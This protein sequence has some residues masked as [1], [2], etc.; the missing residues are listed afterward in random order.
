MR[1]VFSLLILFITMVFFLFFP[2]AYCQEA[3]KVQGK[4]L[5][6]QDGSSASRYRGKEKPKES[7]RASSYELIHEISSGINYGMS[8][9]SVKTADQDAKTTLSDND[10]KARVSYGIILN[11][12]IEPIIEAQYNQS[13]RKVA[14]F[15]E[16]DVSY[17][18]ALGLLLNLPIE[19]SRKG[20]KTSSSFLNASWVPYLGF[21]LG[22]G[23][24]NSKTGNETLVSSTDAGT[25]TNLIFGARYLIYPHV[26]INMSLRLLYEQNQNEAKTTDE[27][28]ATRSE[29]KIDFR[30]LELSLFI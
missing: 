25:Y 22:V 12:N 18:F 10:L 14:D 6:D 11:D 30:L 4:G 19:S 13:K 23:S 7:Q 21:L 16:D 20:N 1:N 24:F 15:I 29:L 8:A 28:G 2:N 17:T 5:A 27:I 3:T 26:A 9:G